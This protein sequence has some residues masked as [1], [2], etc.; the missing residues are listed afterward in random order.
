MI[1]SII[2]LPVLCLLRF[3]YSFLFSVLISWSSADSEV[4]SLV[5]EIKGVKSLLSFNLGQSPK[6]YQCKNEVDGFVIVK[7][8]VVTK[9]LTD[10]VVPVVINVILSYTCSHHPQ[11]LVSGTFSSVRHSLVVLYVVE[12]PLPKES[13]PPP[14]SQRNDGYRRPHRHSMKFLYVMNLLSMK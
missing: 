12:T 3:L 14:T 6:G 10:V 13:L 11:G 9:T 5:E 1:V 8:I 2:L 4:D 7:Y